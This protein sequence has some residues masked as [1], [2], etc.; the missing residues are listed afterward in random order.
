V[1][2][3]LEEKMGVKKGIEARRIVLVHIL[4]KGMAARA[5]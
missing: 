1:R 3:G 2:K 5:E 4:K